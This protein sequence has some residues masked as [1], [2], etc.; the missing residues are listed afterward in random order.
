LSFLIP[1]YPSCRISSRCWASLSSQVGA[2]KRDDRHADDVEGNWPGSIVELSKEGSSDKWCESTSED[3]G[4][5]VTERCST[6]ADICAKQLAKEG[7][8]WTI[9]DASTTDSN[10]QC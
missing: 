3:R 4:Y 5:L 2:D 7:R 10:G 6:I 8:L 9:H 1:C